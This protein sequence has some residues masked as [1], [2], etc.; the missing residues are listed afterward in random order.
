MHMLSTADVFVGTYTSNIGRLVAILREANGL[1]R[2]TS[3]SVDVPTWQSG[4]KLYGDW[5]WKVD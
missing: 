4:R 3:I 1:P 2:K 5:Q